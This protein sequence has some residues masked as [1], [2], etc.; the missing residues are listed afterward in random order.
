MKTKFFLFGTMIFASFFLLTIWT[1]VSA[2]SNTI[3]Y[4]GW[5]CGGTKAE[6]KV[7]ALGYSSG[8][9]SCDITSSTSPSTTIN[10][11]GWTWWQCDSIASGGNVIN[12]S[13]R[14]AKSSPPASSRGDITQVNYCNYGYSPPKCGYSVKAHGTHDFNHSGASQWR[15]YNSTIGP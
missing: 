14:P 15:P 3:P 11:I 7:R 2:S 4:Y 6:A 1:N 9:G 12:S 10:I 13:S 5:C 8:Q